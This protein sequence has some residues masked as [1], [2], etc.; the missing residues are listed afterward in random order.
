MSLIAKT[1][2]NNICEVQV[3]TPHGARKKFSILIFVHDMTSALPPDHLTPLPCLLLRMNWL[4]HQPLIISTR[5]QD[6]LP[7]PHLILSA[8][9]HAYSPKVLSRYDSDTATPASSSPQLTMLT[10]PLHPQYMPLTLPPYVRPH[11][12]LRFCTPPLTMLMLPKD[13]QGMP[14]MLPTHVYPHPS[15]CSRIRSIGYAGLLAYNTITEIF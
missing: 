11:P 15:L 13:P 6:I 10:L 1:H 5:G 2:I 4:P 9:Y 3:T 8:A 7:H 12:S 14:P